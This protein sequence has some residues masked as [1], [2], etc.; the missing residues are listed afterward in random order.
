[1]AGEDR[2]SNRA[3]SRR[4][5]VIRAAVVVGLIVV[6]VAGLLIYEERKDTPAAPIAH[7]SSPIGNSIITAAVST[8]ALPEEISRAVREAPDA[9]QATVANM[10]APVATATEETKPQPHEDVQSEPVKRPAPVAVVT[11]P[12][13]Q[14]ATAPKG[15]D[16]L[17]VDTTK[18][19][20]PP[21][22][23]AA[24]NK[25]PPPAAA[26]QPVVVAPPVAPAIPHATGFMVQLGVFN[27][28]SNAE[29]LRTKLALAGIPTQVETR[30]QLGPFKTREEALK[31]Q[32]TLRTL[33]VAQG[34]LV[35]PRNAEHVGK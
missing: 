33:G 27:N 11:P 8:P 21:T 26:P 1:M 5:L 29:E 35:P 32:Q 22:K 25:N 20:Q 13:P 23:P 3:E 34:L 15:N 12:P 30:V 17:V 10:S 19:A 6:L 2:N 7:V 14:P 16:R 9:T 31:A 4:Q 28:Q 18:Q 24:P